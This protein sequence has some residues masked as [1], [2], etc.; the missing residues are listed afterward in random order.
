MILF[1]APPVSTKRIRVANWGCSTFLYWQTWNHL[2]YFGQWKM[3]PTGNLW[4]YHKC[5][6]D[7]ANSILFFSVSTSLNKARNNTYDMVGWF[8]KSF[9]LSAQHKSTGRDDPPLSPS[10]VHWLC[11]IPRVRVACWENS[12]H[13]HYTPKRPRAQVVWGYQQQ[14][15]APSS[16]RP[17]VLSVPRIYLPGVAGREHHRQRSRW[18]R[19]HS[20]SLSS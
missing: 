13:P 1:V 4:W 9:L 14:T 15:H 10:R 3:E 8:E 17:G 5:S 16:A 19:E 7:F 20:A 11:R 12:P 6:S 2:F 18:V